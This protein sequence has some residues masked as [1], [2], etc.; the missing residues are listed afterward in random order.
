[1][2]IDVGATAID[3]PSSIDGSANTIIC[4]YN[5]ANEAGTITSVQVYM[6]RNTTGMKVGT[7]YGSG[8]SWTCRAAASLG[9]VTGGSEQS[10]SV[11]LAC[12][13][14]DILGLYYSD[15]ATD[16]D[17]GSGALLGYCAGD[18]TDGSTD[19][20]DTYDGTAMASV[21]GYSIASVGNLP[22]NIVISF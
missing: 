1:M 16:Y 13:A 17:G 3:R 12:E 20:Y 22:K 7:F 10:F 11:S 6:T 2:A 19:T 9:D 18:Q 4:A 14:G 21:Y 8:S 15:G 5:P